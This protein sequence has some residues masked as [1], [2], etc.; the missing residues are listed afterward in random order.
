MN[1]SCGSSQSVKVTRNGN[2]IE[3]EMID[4]ISKEGFVI[5]NEVINQSISDDVPWALGCE[6]TIAL[7]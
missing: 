4:S 1:E 5:R 6:G 3:C 7:Y 2:K